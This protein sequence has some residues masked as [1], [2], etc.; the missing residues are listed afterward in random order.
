MPTLAKAPRPRGDRR[1]VVAVNSGSS[2]IKFALFELDALPN[3][4]ARGEIERIGSAQASFSV[5]TGTPEASHPQA[6]DAPNHAA[7]AHHIIAWLERA[8]HGRT[9]AAI[10]HR[11]VHGGFRYYEPMV[12][13]DTV[14]AHL[15]ELAP[16]LPS[17]LPSELAV[18][19]AFQEAFPELPQIACFD[20]GFHRDLPVISR[21]LPLP[22]EYARAGLRRCGFH[23]LSY[24]FLVEE[25]E[26]TAGTEAANGRLIL[27]HLGSGAS[28][29]AVY[30]GRPID[31]TMG[32]TPTGGLVMG[33]RTG[34]LDPGTLLYLARTRGLSF[35]ALEELTSHRSGLLGV[36]ETSSDIRALLAAERTDPRAAE[37][38]AL[39]CYQAKKGIGAFAAALGGLDGLV[40]SGGIG[41]YAP[42]IRARICDGLEHLALKVD[43]ARNESN[44]A[45]ISPQSEAVAVRVIETDEELIIAQ[46]IRGLL[47]GHYR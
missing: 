1:A 44:A 16:Y 39:F 37:A 20:T 8:A 26:R 32:F 38:V 47:N 18:T 35:E 15:G 13:T 41:T 3:E 4:L 22:R 17:H 34:D 21:H 9:L 7:A 29:A 24:Q 27:A 33:T 10:G 42:A 46:A 12:L 6:V 19:R 28:L 43:P 5:R 2:S 40:F 36:S 23:G 45:V 30:R 31:T 11:I 14:L 25:L